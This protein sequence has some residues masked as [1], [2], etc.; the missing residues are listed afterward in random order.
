VA[1]PQRL[2]LQEAREVPGLVRQAAQAVGTSD[3]EV[4]AM[5]D[6]TTRRLRDLLRL[7]RSPFDLSVSGSVRVDGI[8]GL[9]RLRP[10]LELEVVPKFLDARTQTWQEDFFVL[11]LFSQTGRILPRERISA[12]HGHRGDLASLVGQTF[13]RMYSENQRRPV[14]AYRHRG[15]T[16]FAYDGDVDPLDLFAPEPDGFP[17]R[18]LQLR[19]DNEYNSVLAGAVEAL[20]PEVRDAETRKQL[21]RVR[22]ALGPQAPVRQVRPLRLPARHREWQQLHDLAVEVLRGFGVGYVQRHL[23]APGFVLR[24][25]ETWQ[26]LVEAALRT[27]LSGVQVLGQRPYNLGQ[28]TAQPLDVTPDVTVLRSGVPVGVLDAKY[29]TRQGKVLSVDAGDVYETLAFLRAT[30]TSRAVLLYPRPA[31]GQPPLPVG[32]CQQFEQVTVGNAVIT[33]LAAEV[34]G[35]SGTDGYASFAQRLAAAVQPHLP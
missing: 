24:T 34:R 30:G 32:S 26:A 29:R 11:A 28:R 14:R 10:D 2:T 8:A 18:V 31:D 15:A 9:L 25:W 21:V 16:E 17:Q 23:L 7:R 6:S 13:A 20:L 3:A 35:I 22:Q 5:F 12:G 27:A 19:R 1:G 33:A 4:F